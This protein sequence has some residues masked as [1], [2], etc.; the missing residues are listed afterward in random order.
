MKKMPVVLQS[1]PSATPTENL[2]AVTALLQQLF[3]ATTV[4]KVADDFVSSVPALGHMNQ[5]SRNSAPKLGVLS[6]A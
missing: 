2:S 5:M 6:N 1:A 4:H 3:A